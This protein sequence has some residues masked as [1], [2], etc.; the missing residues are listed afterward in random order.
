MVPARMLCIAGVALALS[1]VAVPVAAQ[2]PTTASVGYQA[3]HW[4][5]AWVPVGVNFDVAVPRG[6]AWSVVGEFGI[7]HD[8]DDDEFGDTR[9]FNIFNLGGGIRWGRAR[10]GVTPFAQVLAGVQIS[11]SDTDTDTAFMLQPGAGVQVPIGDRWAAA[12]QVDYRPVF[13]REEIVN[14]VRLVVGVRRSFR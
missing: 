5:G 9:G 4:P 8:G 7:V 2:T 13:Y 1:L 12:A 6:D 10:A 14:E 11:N 3:L